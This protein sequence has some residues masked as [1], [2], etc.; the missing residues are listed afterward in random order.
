MRLLLIVGASVCLALLAGC[1]G[2]GGVAPPLPPADSLVVWQFSSLT[3][4]PPVLP[5]QTPPRPGKGV[6]VTDPLYGTTLVRVSDRAA[7]GYASPGLVNEYAR[8][9]PENADGTLAL[10]RGTEGDWHLYDVASGRHLRAVPFRGNPDPEPRWD[11]AN[12]DLATFVEGSS[13]WEWHAGSGA[14]S[15]LRSFAGEAPGCTFVRTR[16]EGEP[17]RDGRYFCLRLEDAG[18]RLLQVVCYDR[19]TDRVVG[20][21]SPAEGDWDWVS[22]DLS[23]THCLLGPGDNSAG[24]AYRRD[25]T[26]PVA[27][28]HGLGH[29]DVALDAAGRDVLVYQNAATD[30]IAMVDLETGVE[31]NLVPIPFADNTD[32]GLHFSGNCTMRPGWV[33]VSTYGGQVTARSWMDQC[34]FVLQLRSHPLIWRLAQTFCLQ[35]PGGEADYFAEAFAAVNSRGTRVWWGANWNARGAASRRYETY[36]ALLPAD[37]EAQVQAASR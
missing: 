21:L 25:F 26:H 22:M 12:P 3:D 4:K 35:D 24:L 7:D 5:F 13:L 6:A 31:T 17:S 32:I 33:L 34:L 14:V 36:C 23:G 27:L 30:W 18:Y 8:A 2:G 19:E 37:W 28:P 11:P 20:R 15:R 1:G 29:A 9:D 16:Y 10:L